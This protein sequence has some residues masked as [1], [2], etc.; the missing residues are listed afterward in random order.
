MEIVATSLEF[1]GQ[2]KAEEVKPDE[3]TFVT[4][5]VACRPAVEDGRNLFLAMTQDYGIE[6]RTVHYNCMVDLLGRAGHLEEAER[7]I[8]YMPLEP[9]AI[10]C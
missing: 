10:P 5:L 4:D 2:M 7:F 9:N 8:R 6:H 1:I 3:C